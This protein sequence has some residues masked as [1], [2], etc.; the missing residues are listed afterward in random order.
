MNLKNDFKSVKSKGKSSFFRLGFL[1]MIICLGAQMA[2][3]NEKTD[4]SD[5]VEVKTI[6]STVT[7]TITDEMGQVLPGTTIIEK[8]TT[9]GTQ[10][11]FD[12]N[13]SL[14]VADGAVLV[15]SYVGFKTQEVVVNGQSTI[16]VTMVEDAAALD[17]VVVTG[18]STQTRG[19]LTGSVGSVD[20]SEA[21][22]TPMVNAAE[23]LQGR[24][25]RGYYHQ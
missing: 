18:Y 11:D 2:L 22:K 10:S 5:E 16:N 20:V 3:A 8:G 15:F 1:S 25:S 6:Q 24:V 12:G 7:G 19:D 17:E 4:T 21:T 14:N 13:Y 9:N 23:A